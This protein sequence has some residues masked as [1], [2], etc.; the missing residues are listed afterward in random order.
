[1]S[2]H[3]CQTIRLTNYMFAH[4]RAQAIIDVLSQLP[5]TMLFLHTSAA[6]NDRQLQAAL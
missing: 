6:R 2:A 5:L 1:M 3:S 4:E